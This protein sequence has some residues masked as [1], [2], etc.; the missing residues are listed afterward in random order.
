MN[1]GSKLSVYNAQAGAE[2]ATDIAEED[3]QNRKGLLGFMNTKLIPAIMGG[4]A[5]YE[6]GKTM[7]PIRDSI[8][9][10]SQEMNI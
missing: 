2:I 4:T 1:I 7:S 10:R 3:A 6:I 5:G 9:R 8:N